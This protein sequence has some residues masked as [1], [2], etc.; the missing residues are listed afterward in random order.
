MSWILNICVA[1]PFAQTRSAAAIA[2]GTLISLSEQQLVDCSKAEHN[3]GCNGGLMDYGFEYI[4]HN[5]GITTESDYA[6]TA[7]DGTCQ[8]DKAAHHVVT[9]SDYHDVPQNNM[10]QLEQAVS[11]GPVSIAI[12]ADKSVF[13]LYNGGVFTDEAGC[14]TQLDHGVLT[15]GYGTDNGQDYWIVKNSWGATWGE[16]GY[17]RLGKTTS[18]KGMCGMYQQPSYPEA[19]DA[20]PT[21][22]PG[23]GPSPS[24][25]TGPYE[26]PA[27]G[28]E[29]DEIAIRI[30]GVSGSFCSPK[31]TGIFS[32]KCPSVPSGMQGMAECALKTSTGS[33]YCAVIPFMPDGTLGHLSIHPVH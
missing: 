12:E 33:K 13:Q 7:R 28:C 25:S 20:G 8:G 14:G 19:K 11:Q 15:V 23:P 4:E 24:P 31:C 32:D 26:N 27:N 2:S 16:Q 1:Q 30:Q 6:Y 10:E 5:A 22:P 29:E 9:V 3:N 21:P 17:I 18:G